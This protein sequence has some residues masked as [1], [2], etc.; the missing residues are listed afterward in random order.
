MM[1]HSKKQGAPLNEQHPIC[2]TVFGLTNGVFL[3]VGKTKGVSALAAA[4]RLWCS[5]ASTPGSVR[6]CLQGSGLRGHADRQTRSMCIPTAPVHRHGRWWPDRERSENP[7]RFFLWYTKMRDDFNI[8]HSIP[9]N[10]DI[11]SRIFVFTKLLADSIIIAQQEKRN[12]A[13]WWCIKF[14]RCFCKSWQ[15]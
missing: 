15:K 10:W 7:A 11:T 5:Q 9:S 8:I 3:Y 12:Y 2:P 4:V 1:N 14:S 6:W 13:M